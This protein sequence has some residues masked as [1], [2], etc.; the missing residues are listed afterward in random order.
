MY[1][2][3]WRK[4]KVEK[5]GVGSTLIYHE[6]RFLLIKSLTG[7]TAGLWNTP[8]G[9]LED[10]ETFEEAA[11]RE[12][13]EETGYKV[14][15]GKLVNVYY[16]SD[17]KGRQV[18]KR[19]YEGKIVGGELRLEGGKVLQVLWLSGNEVPDLGPATFGATQ[20]IR[21]YL[22]GKLGTVHYPQRIA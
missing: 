11:V 16:F 22:N 6:G 15:L 2:N 1:V 7:P 8:G 17:D 12:T 19:V 20:S 14:E 21:D 5:I 13:F 10:G 3:S 4:V 18:I 9:K